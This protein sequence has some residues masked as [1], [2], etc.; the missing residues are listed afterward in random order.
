VK[1]QSTEYANFDRVMRKLIAVP[2]EK[3]KVALD[4]E[5]QAKKEKRKAKK[6]SA[7]DRASR[8]QG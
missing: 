1:K 8:E 6:S 3:L 2:H 5:K 4:A 7:S